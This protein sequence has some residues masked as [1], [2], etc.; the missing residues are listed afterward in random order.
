MAARWTFQ[1]KLLA[2]RK[3]SIHPSAQGCTLTPR[4]AWAGEQHLCRAGTLPGAH[5]ALESSTP[6]SWG[7]PGVLVLQSCEYPVFCSFKN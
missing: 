1:E 7:F 5:T 3:G 4:W 2:Q 6:L